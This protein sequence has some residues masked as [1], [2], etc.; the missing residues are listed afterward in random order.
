MR[1]ASV[2]LLATLILSLF[3]PSEAGGLSYAVCQAK[4]AALCS[5]AGFWIPGVGFVSCYAYAQ[6]YCSYLL[7]PVVP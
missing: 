4:A 6:Y 7:L 1:L 5:A 3:L 2:L